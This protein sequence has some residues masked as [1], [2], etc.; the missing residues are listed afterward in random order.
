M[1]PAGTDE[2]SGHV[3]GTTS[4]TRTTVPLSNTHEHTRPSK[5]FHRAAEPTQ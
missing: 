3:Y 4:L 2:G 1:R 5:L